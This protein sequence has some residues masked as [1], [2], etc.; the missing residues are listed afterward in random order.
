MSV[1]TKQF[2]RTSHVWGESNWRKGVVIGLQGL[3]LEITLSVRS[4]S[5]SA[6]QTVIT[7]ICALFT[8]S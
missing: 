8:Y 3:I 6:T 4:E 5:T 1:Q 2:E 7:I